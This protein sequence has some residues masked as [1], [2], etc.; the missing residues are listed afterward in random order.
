MLYVHG[1]SDYFFQPH[2]ADFWESQGFDFYAVE[3][4][5]YGRGLGEGMLAGY[6]ADLDE[7]AE[8]IDLAVAQVSRDHEQVTLH[9]HSTGGLVGALYADSHPGLFEGVVLNSPWLDMQGSALMR[10]VAVT[11]M[12][13]IGSRSPTTPIPLPD[14]GFYAR[15]ISAELDG[16]WTFDA[17]RKAGPR[18]GIWAGWMRAISE[19][20]KRISR[21]LAIETPVQVLISA[22]SDFRR[23]WDAEALGACDTVLDVKRLA[24]ASAN[25]G[26]CVTLVRIEGGLHDLALSR[27]EVRQVYFDEI[28]RWLGAYVR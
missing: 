20:H 4:R 11:V 23:T 1:W 14:N 6:I 24:A 21:G 15:T 17:D 28:A 10:T 25:L 22:R 16:E 13:Q 7:Y 19:G 2:V 9:A 27:S 12:R 5:R 3:L 18:F 26:R 8:E